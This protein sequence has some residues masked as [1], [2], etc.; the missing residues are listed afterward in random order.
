MGRIS[1]CWDLKWT[2]RQKCIYKLTL[3]PKRCPKK[4]IKTFMI[5][6]FI[7]EFLKKFETAWMVYSGA[8]GKRIHEKNQKS[9]ISW[10]CPFTLFL[11]LTSLFSLHHISPCF[12]VCPSSFYYI[13]KYS[14]QSTLLRPFPPCPPS[15]HHSYILWSACVRAGISLMTTPPLS[16][17]GLLYTQ[18][19]MA[20]LKSHQDQLWTLPYSTYILVG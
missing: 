9:K 2:W 8:L 14:I 18:Y 1:G 3:L 17:A 5:E 19:S 15:F 6:D 12:S 13:G 11:H 10:H 20:R 4:I 16:A 7:R